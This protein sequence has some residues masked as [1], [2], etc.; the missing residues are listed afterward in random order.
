MSTRSCTE[1]YEV[2]EYQGTV[3]ERVV[4]L[5]RHCDGYPSVAGAC[6]LEALAKSKSPTDVAASL[7]SHS[8]EATTYRPAQLIYE[9][10]TAADDHGDLEH[11]YKVWKTPTGWRI[12]HNGTEYSPEEFAKIVSADQ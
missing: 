6:L 12:D 2:R 9:L 7:L 4:A 8:Y 3:K 1:L 10:T 5:Y 11:T